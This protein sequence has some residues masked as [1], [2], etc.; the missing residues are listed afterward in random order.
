MTD[1]ELQRLFIWLRRPIRWDPVPPWIK[2]NK[3]QIAK[4]TEVQVRLN[5]KIAEIEAQKMTELSKIAGIS[6]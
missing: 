2:L 3:E 5:T 6:K 4:F 1:E